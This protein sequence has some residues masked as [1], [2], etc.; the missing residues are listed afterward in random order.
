MGSL[1]L[2]PLSTPAVTYVDGDS[3]AGLA[4]DGSSWVTAFPTLQDALDCVRNGGC[5]TEIWV[6]AG[7]Y[8]PDEGTGHTPDDPTESFYLVEGV[9][10]YGGFDGVGAGGVG[11]AQEIVRSDRQVTTNKTILSGDI[12][13]DDIDLNGNGIISNANNIVGTNSEHVVYV[14][15]TGLGAFSSAT[16]LN[17]FYITAGAGGALGGGGLICHGSVSDSCDPNFTNL[18][19]RGN[20]AYIGGAM[21]NNYSNA[22]VSNVE[23]SGNIARSLPGWGGAIYNFSSNVTINDVTCRNNEADFGGCIYNNESDPTITDSR[24]KSNSANSHGGAV[25]NDDSSPT[26]TDA[27]F[28]A[29]SAAAW[30]GAVFNINSEPVLLNAAFNGNSASEGGAIFDEISG[31]FSGLTQLTNVVFSGNTATGGSGGAIHSWWNIGQNLDIQLTNATFNENSATVAG[32][33][34]Y[35]EANTYTCAGIDVDIVN[36]ILWGSTNGA[37]ANE[38]HVESGDVTLS[39]SDLDGLGAA[40]VTVGACGIFTNAGN[41]ISLPPEFVDPHGADAIL[42]T[43]DDNLH[44]RGQLFA[45]PSPA[46]DA[47]NNAS[48]TAASDFDGLPRILDGDGSGTAEVDMGAYEVLLFELPDIDIILPCDSEPGAPPDPLDPLCW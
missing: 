13:Q 18:F 14:N 24:F 42:G 31:G 21:Y 4:A 6:A 5:D 22:R 47:G 8:F 33:A 7:E 19:F 44:L 37:V 20:Q 30:G 34:I 23:F 28:L 35:I 3:T 41:N 36:S 25:F 2:V 12:I 16:K 10:L 27:M 39:Y 11:G 9:S 40:G 46:I 26:L 29:N 32:G 15:A 1:L 38:I 48:V 45:T 43:L 17:G